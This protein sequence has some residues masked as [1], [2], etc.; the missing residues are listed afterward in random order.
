MD[1]VIRFGVSLPK[2]L[3][4][5]FDREIANKGYNNRSEAIRDLIREFLVRQEIDKDME[6]VGT[7]TIVYNHH[8]RDINDNLTAIQHESYRH[9]HSNMHIHLDHDNCLEV[10][11]LRGK[12]ST[13]SKIAD[14]IIGSRGVKHGKLTFTS[15][16]KN[17]SG[18]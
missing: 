5:R 13:I 16:G 10:I 3:L 9:I 18:V 1:K 17:L 7:L 15:T 2:D 4:V 14:K 6:V 8:V 11:V 12:Y